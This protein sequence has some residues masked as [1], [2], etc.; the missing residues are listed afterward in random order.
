[1]EKRTNTDILYE[2]AIE[3]L[4]E[5]IKTIDGIDNKIGITFGLAN[6][7]IAALI[8]FIALIKLPVS[9]PVII[10]IGLSIFAY[11]ITL[12]FL[13]Y[14]YRFSKWSYNPNVKILKEFCFDPKYKEYPDIIKSWVADNCIISIELNRESIKE[15]LTLAYIALISV[16]AQ[17]I[18]LAISCFIY[19]LN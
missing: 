10:V 11:L 18:F 19:L 4:N 13:F 14:A 15:K 5:Q 3:R 9:Q 6:G 7:I 1:M 2:I 16:S 12:V 17:G 8:A